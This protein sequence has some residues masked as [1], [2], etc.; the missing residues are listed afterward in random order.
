MSEARVAKFVKVLDE[1]VVDL[2]ALKEL[3]WSGIPAPLRA[4]CWR[5]LLGYLPPNKERRDTMLARKRKEY[6][7]ASLC[8]LKKLYVNIV[9]IYI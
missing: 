5:L 7:S 8:Y 9:Y 2:D 1:P 4:D 3:A 6:R